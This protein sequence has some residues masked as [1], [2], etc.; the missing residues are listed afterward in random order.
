M[1]DWVVVGMSDIAFDLAAR[2]CDAERAYACSLLHI[3]TAE[4]VDA[5]ASDDIADPVARGIHATAR[6]LLDRGRPVDPVTL[7][8]EAVSTLPGRWT[9][10]VPKVACHPGSVPVNWPTYAAAVR[11]G[12]YRRRAVAVAERI[13]QAAETSTV[14]R[15]AEVLRSAAGLAVSL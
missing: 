7:V 11:E 2:Y 15:L 14:D 13:V 8:L 5:V 12:A 9:E 10:H 6:V 4:V 3:G 1:A